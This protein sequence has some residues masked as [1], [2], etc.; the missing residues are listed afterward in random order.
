MRLMGLLLLVVSTSAFA[1]NKCRDLSTYIIDKPVSF[2]KLK[3]G[4]AIEKLTV[5]TGLIVRSVDSVDSTLSGKNITGQLDLVLR[6]MADDAHFSFWQDGCQLV[7][8]PVGANGM[9]SWSVQKG[10]TLYAAL[11]R[12]ARQAGWV[13]SYEVDGMVT[14]GGEL[15]F[16]GEFE[17]S[18][19]L[20]LDT[21]GKSTGVNVMH[22]FYYGNRTLR[23]FRSALVDAAK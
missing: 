7:A 5:G 4:D 6:K 3:L 14:L 1:G 23:V 17:G 2:H 15:S 9:P 20:L 11:S 13:L 21:I 12:W 18:V 8:V 19:D 22:K 10:E 16:E